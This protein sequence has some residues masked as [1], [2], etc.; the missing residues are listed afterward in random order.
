M[1]WESY[2][3]VYNNDIVLAMANSNGS[4]QMSN[5]NCVAPSNYLKDVMDWSKKK[6]YHQCYG[7]TIEIL[8]K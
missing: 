8:Q 1:I 2:Q 3:K 7:T 4:R 6:R 5:V